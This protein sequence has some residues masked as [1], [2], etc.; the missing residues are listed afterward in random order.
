MT[1]IDH[2]DIKAAANWLR[3]NK[4]IY[5]PHPKKNKPH[6]WPWTY[7]LPVFQDALASGPD[8]S[9]VFEQSR[10]NLFKPRFVCA[11]SM[12]NNTKWFALLSDTQT[13]NMIQFP[14]GNIRKNYLRYI[15]LA[16]VLTGGF[17]FFRRCHLKKANSNI[18]GKILFMYYVCAVYGAK[19]RNQLA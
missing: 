3:T 4:T 1:L 13:R 2:L 9:V 6:Y 11:V 15:Y 17:R 14:E 19:D 7:V 18:F 8:H 16:F 10:N 5:H 12:M